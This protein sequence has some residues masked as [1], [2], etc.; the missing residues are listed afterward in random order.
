MVEKQNSL[1]SN[2]G[3]QR[4]FG[5]GKVFFIVSVTPILRRLTSYFVLA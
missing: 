1:F 2:P 4:G 3:E 5:V